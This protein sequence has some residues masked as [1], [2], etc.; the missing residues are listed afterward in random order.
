M[1]CLTLISDAFLHVAVGASWALVF[2]ESL[3]ARRTSSTRLALEAYS[4][5]KLISKVWADDAIRAFQAVAHCFLAFKRIV[6]S[7]RAWNWKDGRSSF[8]GRAVVAFG[9]GTAFIW[10]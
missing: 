7:L 1:R 8:S 9:A 6:S 5:A 10:S 4:V 2:V 3:C